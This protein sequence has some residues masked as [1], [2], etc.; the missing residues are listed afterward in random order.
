MHLGVG[1]AL[2]EWFGNVG[3]VAPKKK[4]ALV[5]GGGGQCWGNSHSGLSLNTSPTRLFRVIFPEGSAV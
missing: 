3:P 4:C 1:A 2:T 5:A